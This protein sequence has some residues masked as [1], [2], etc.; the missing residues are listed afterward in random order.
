MQPYPVKTARPNFLQNLSEIFSD[1]VEG[2]KKKAVLQQKDTMPGTSLKSG[3][4]FAQGAA[5]L[6]LEGGG[7]RSGFSGPLG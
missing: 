5:A 1:N 6:C 4:G 3:R 2:E 7:W